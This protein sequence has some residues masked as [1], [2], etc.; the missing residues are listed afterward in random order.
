[1]IN[2]LIG[3]K[4][5]QTQKFL[6]NGKRVPVTLIA[7]GDNAVLQ[8][9][10]QAADTYT[11]VQIGFGVKKKPTKASAG[12][13][14][15]AGFDKVSAVIKEIRVADDDEVPAAGESITLDQVFAPGDIVAVTGTS[16]GK[17]FAGVV[18][19]H[20]FRG[21]PKTHGQSDRHRAPGSIGQTTTPGRVYKGKRMAG[22][23]GSDQVTLPNLTVLGVDLEKKVLLITG[24]VPGHKDAIVSITKTGTRKNFLE[25]VEE[26]V[27]R[28]AREAIEAAEAA[29][30]AEKAAKIAE[31]EAAK[32]AAAAPKEETK[33]E[34]E[35]K[36][37]EVPVETASETVTTAEEA[38]SDTTETVT[39]P[40][41]AVEEKAEEVAVEA[42]VEEIKESEAK[43]EEKK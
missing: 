42:E 32:A 4:I 6:E 19:R 29:K 37:E 22:R 38:V 14:K 34:E 8:V 39:T 21:G 10:T 25:L 36:G 24:L 41:E 1:M 28:E 30:E 5:D 17:G 9:K 20:N 43:V 11:A 23:M 35:A 27:K 13:A 3:K 26:K 33:V 12:H 40:E 2:T 18:K 16:K 7:V 15:K 31:E